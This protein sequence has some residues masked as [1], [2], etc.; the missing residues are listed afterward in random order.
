[1]YFNIQLNLNV[2]F[3]DEAQHKVNFKKIS[4]TTTSSAL[5]KPTTKIKL[6]NAYTIVLFFNV[7]F[8]TTKQK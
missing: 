2:I 7:H 8:S 3:L 5:K 4:T 1:M 6:E